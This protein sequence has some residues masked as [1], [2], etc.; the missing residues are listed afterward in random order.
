MNSQRGN[1]IY[2]KT[3]RSG[4]RED[5]VSTLK[6]GP[7][8]QSVEL[9][10]P[11]IQVNPWT[12]D[13]SDAQPMGT[14]FCGP[15]LPPRF[16]QSVQSEHGSEHSDHHS[17]Y[18]EQ[19][20]KVCSCRAKNTRT[21]RKHKVQAKYFSQSSSSEEDQSSVP[22]KKSAKPQKA[23]VQDQQQNNPDPVFYREVDMPDSLHSVQRKLRLL[24]T[25]L[26]SPTQG[27]YA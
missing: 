8:K 10:D 18:S 19:P 22:I 14:D 6:A 16:S 27:N 17:E 25:Y 23:P 15:S 26:I 11:N 7:S 5:L 12:S 21:K 9:S 2:E 13:H 20:E 4:G 1:E 3:L 24:G